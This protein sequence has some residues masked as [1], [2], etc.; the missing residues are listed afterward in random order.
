ML[1]LLGN[2]A[3]RAMS[4][5]DQEI[6]EQAVRSSPVLGPVLDQWGHVQLPNAWLVAGA[7]AQTV[8]NSRL[9]FPLDHGISDVDIV[10]FDAGNLS[11]EAEQNE[12]RRI[13][14]LFATSPVQFDVKNEAR[15][16]LWYKARFGYEIAPYQSVEE[17]IASFPTTASAI[18]IRQSDKRL[19]LIAPFGLA[20]LCG[21]VVRPN[22]VQ[23]DVQTYE[24]KVS[25]WRELWPSLNIRPWQEP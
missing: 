10:Y 5:T 2:S 16:H 14:S 3:S 11:I 23:V 9:C 22:K 13:R 25:R 19:E 6:L 4:T 12:E 18:G 20:D 15:V 21:L 17:A 7:V 1:W 24:L 8:W